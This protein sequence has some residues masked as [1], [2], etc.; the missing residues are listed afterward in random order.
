[1]VAFFT[2]LQKAPFFSP[3]CFPIGKVIS[4]A[5]DGVE[6]CPGELSGKKKRE[7]SFHAVSLQIGVLS[8]QIKGSLI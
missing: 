2:A 3:G 5:L 1:M 4:G 6:E 8:A 7:S